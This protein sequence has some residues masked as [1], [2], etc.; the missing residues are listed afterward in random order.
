MPALP[1]LLGGT[2]VESTVGEAGKVRQA[3][4]EA[5]AQSYRAEFRHK[6]VGHTAGHYE[7]RS[8]SAAEAA[9]AGGRPRFNLLGRQLHT[10][11][12]HCA[13]RHGPTAPTQRIG[14]KIC[15]RTMRASSPLAP[16]SVAVVSG[17]IVVDVSS[18]LRARRAAA[19]A[20]SL[21]IR[22]RSAGGR[23]LDVVDQ[24]G[25]APPRDC[26]AAGPSADAPPT[27]AAGPS[28]SSSL[29]GGGAAASDLR[30]LLQFDG[31]LTEAVAADRATALLSAMHAQ[32]EELFRTKLQLNYY[33]ERD[34]L[35]ARCA[36]ASKSVLAVRLTVLCVFER[37]A[38]LGRS[39]RSHCAPART[40]PTHSWR[41]SVSRWQNSPTFA[42]C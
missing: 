32:S 31:T 6:G 11:A 1:K 26:E 40:P 7:L 41:A 17:S 3:H 2:R 14:G 34:R 27:E 5:G 37:S 19:G 36:H 16:L 22:T 13:P 29:E 15:F 24:R 20:T 8:P 38:S 12:R 9:V 39:C 42:P 25:R 28:G 30:Q 4:A 23:S 33:E 10:R 18:A 21:R 35:E